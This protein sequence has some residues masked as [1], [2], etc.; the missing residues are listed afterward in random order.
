[1]DRVIPILAAAQW[2]AGSLLAIVAVRRS[3]RYGVAGAPPRA[4]ALTALVILMVAAIVL[5]L[6]STRASVLVASLFPPDFTTPAWRLSKFIEASV[7]AWAVLAV[8][9]FW[10]ATMGVALRRRVASAELRR[11]TERVMAHNPSPDG[12]GIPPELRR[13]S[14]PPGSGTVRPASPPAHREPEPPAEGEPPRY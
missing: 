1:M 3:R 9:G 13:P 2:I 7:L 14:P 5:L 6:A 8:A 11:R 4:L 12:R 10:N